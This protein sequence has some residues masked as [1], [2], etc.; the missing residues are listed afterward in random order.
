MITPKRSY[1][2]LYC[3]TPRV[4]ENSEFD[5]LGF[6]EDR[7]NVVNVEV[8]VVVLSKPSLLDRYTLDSSEVAQEGSLFQKKDLQADV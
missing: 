4:E 2:T 5:F 1:A 3:R 6:D 7:L 8:L